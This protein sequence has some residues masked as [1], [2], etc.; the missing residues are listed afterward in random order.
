MSRRVCQHFQDGEVRNAPANGLIDLC[1]SITKQRQAIYPS[2]TCLSTLTPYYT[3][4]CTA[5]V[6][7]AF[8]QTA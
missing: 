3:S 2:S 4:P 1:F 5:A 6:E 8:M 7:T